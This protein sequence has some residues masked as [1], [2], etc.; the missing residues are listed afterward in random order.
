MKNTV[1]FLVPH[2]LNRLLI[3]IV[4]SVCFLVA[5]CLEHDQMQKNIEK[6]GGVACVLS[7]C[8][9]IRGRL[10]EQEYLTDIPTNNC[11]NYLEPQFISLLNVNGVEFYNIQTSGGFHHSGYLLTAKTNHVESLPFPKW[12]KKCIGTGIFI[13]NE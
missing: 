9:N 10:L 2:G 7:A 3:I 11:L 13:Y 5:G 6:A 1:K 4:I 8:H 12:S